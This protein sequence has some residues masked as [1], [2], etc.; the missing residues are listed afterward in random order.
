M[1]NRFGKCAKHVERTSYCMIAS[2][3]LLIA[4]LGTFIRIYLRIFEG[5]WSQGHIPEL[6]GLLVVAAITGA[7]GVLLAFVTVHRLR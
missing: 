5:A 7:L 6:W 2:V 3:V 1:C 4:S